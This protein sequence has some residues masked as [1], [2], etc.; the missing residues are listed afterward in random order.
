MTSE[1]AYYES[2]LELFFS[3]KEVFII[4]KIHDPALPVPF[5]LALTCN[6]KN[7]MKRRPYRL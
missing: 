5:R 4:L 3:L 6:Q 2:L 7:R 1:P